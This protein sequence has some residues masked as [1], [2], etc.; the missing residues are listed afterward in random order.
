MELVTRAVLFAA[1]AHD[2][3]HRKSSHIPYI[4]HPMEAAAIAASVTE[5]EHVIAAAVL[6]D[7]VEDTDVTE[8]QVEALFG[9]RVAELVG[10]DSE[11]KR[12]QIPA[13][14]TWRIRK[15]ESLEL[16][17]HTDD[18][19]VKIIFLADKLAN[20]RA[21]YRDIRKKGD[22]VWQIFNQKDPAQHGWYYRT[23]ALLTSELKEHVAW[24]EYD[25]LTKM[26][27][28]TEIHA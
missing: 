21:L 17:R 14:D 11:D 24:Q 25:R 1:E 7:V 10:S 28:G 9:R 13:E 3:A 27:F 26:I 19:G 12:E 20:I 8:E 23:I 6:H 5:D 18:I 2:G 16:L 15:E 4:V 22:E